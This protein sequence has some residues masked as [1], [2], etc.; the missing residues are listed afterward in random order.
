MTLSIQSNVF[1]AVPPD[2]GNLRPIQFGDLSEA[3]LQS[4]AWPT[5][6]IR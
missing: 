6:I 3:E 4:H 2:D 5:L 1:R